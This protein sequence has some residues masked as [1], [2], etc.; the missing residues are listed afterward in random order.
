MAHDLLAEMG[1]RQRDHPHEHEP[2]KRIS[3]AVADI[4]VSVKRIGV[5]LQVMHGTWFSWD[6]HDTMVLFS[7]SLGA[8]RTLG[9]S[10]GIQFV[11][12]LIRVG[13]QSDERGGGKSIR[14]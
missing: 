12:Q 9:I 5:L 4:Q 2:L 8:S 14:L 10:F 3:L 7:T 1:N 13:A 11:S 6:V